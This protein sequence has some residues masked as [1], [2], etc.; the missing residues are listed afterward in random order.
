MPN[1]RDFIIRMMSRTVR[2]NELGIPWKLLP[3]K[4]KCKVA[5]I[6]TEGWFVHLKQYPFFP[7]AQAGAQMMMESAM[8]SVFV[9][10]YRGRI[11]FQDAS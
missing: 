7:Y 5:E 11:L 3:Q 9:I 4:G 2:R 1:S 10:D 6:T 8:V